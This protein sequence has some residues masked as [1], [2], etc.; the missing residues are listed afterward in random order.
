MLY[1]TDP[2]W[3]ITDEDTFEFMEN[4]LKVMKGKIDEVHEDIE[5]VTS[6]KKKEALQHGEN[7][8]QPLTCSLDHC[9]IPSTLSSLPFSLSS[10]TCSPLL[11]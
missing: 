5:G 4:M 8:S 7:N 6:R 3:G 10:L 9:V 11:S 1:S 2:T